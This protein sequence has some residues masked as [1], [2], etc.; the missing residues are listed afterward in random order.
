[1]VDIDTHRVVDLIESR[2]LE[3]V[4]NW[5]C[6]FP[7]LV[8]VSRDGSITYKNAITS[9]HPDA[10]Q[11]SDRFHI[12]KNLTG[13]C[14]DFLMN[15]FKSKILVDETIETQE[16]QLTTAQKNRLL[17]LK[18]KISIALKMCD[19]GKLK[20]HICEQLN[21]DIRVLK[22]LLELTEAERTRYFQT[23]RDIR[24]SE[25][26]AR[27]QELA[28]LVRVMKQTMSVKGIG[29]ELS[30][31]RTTINR[32]IDPNFSPIHNSTGVGKTSILNP[33][34]ETIE[35]LLLEGH[36]SSSIIKRIQSEGYKGSDSNVRHYCSNLKNGNIAAMSGVNELKKQHYV[37][38][39][40]LLKLLYI[41]FEKVR[42]IN[43]DELA[44]VHQRYPE[45]KHIIH[46]VNKFRTMLKEKDVLALDQWLEDAKEF[47]NSYLNSFINGITR[48]IDAV[49]NAITFSYSNG[50]AEGSVNKLKVIKR[51]MYGRNSF[52]L[53]K[54][55]LLRLEFNRKIN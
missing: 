37:E 8:V 42:K 28:D 6:S 54:K 24:C 29:K 12:L 53:L 16:I 13:Y 2:D 19:Q 9:S 43:E 1:M 18:E 25:K 7:N 50:L 39:K 47:N 26:V 3:D 11:V 23:V 36:K 55:K 34:K 22:K 32:Y 17:P 30:L 15:Y 33:F 31:S 14:K 27:K 20:S 49:K 35:R 51:I 44:K 4:K 5:L 41:P 40:E 38:R 48:D 45:F 46:L 21:I 52:E 10:L